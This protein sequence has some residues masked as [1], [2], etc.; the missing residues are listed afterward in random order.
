[1]TKFNRVASRILALGLLAGAL[2]ACADTGPRVDDRFTVYT[3]IFADNRVY[4]LKKQDSGTQRLESLGA[5]D[6][7][8]AVPRNSALSVIVRSI[9]L[10]ARDKES[11]LRDTADY[12]VILDVGTAA[13]GSSQS[14]VVWYQRGVR[15]DQS[16]NFSNLLVFYEP[17]WDERVAPFFRVRVMDVTT[18]RNAETRRTLERAGNIASGVGALAGSPLVAPLIGVAFSAAELVLANQQNRMVLDYSVQ[19][20]SSAAAAEAGSGN[21][22]VLKRGSYIVVGRPNEEPRSFWRQP[23]TFEP[24]SRTLD[25]PKGR[26]NVPVALITVG[27][28]DSIVPKLVL[29]RSS[30]LTRLLATDPARSTIEEVNESAK[31]LNASVQAFV[32]GERVL[33]YRNIGDIDRILEIMSPGS[34]MKGLIG[35]EDE[36][37]LTRAAE[38]CFRPDKPITSLEQLLA[39]RQQNPERRCVTD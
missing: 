28:F 9:E 17:R 35:A 29:E 2:A 24:D 12:A 7:E 36:F 15:P 1:M 19:L 13:D 33:R 6:R 38:R 32:M 23:F 22:G 4:Y 25:G 30:A 3:P 27:T 8:G 10:P 11:P 21:L 39:Y 16:L 37:F 18:E 26:V 31:R 34:E 14:L 5:G 20:Y